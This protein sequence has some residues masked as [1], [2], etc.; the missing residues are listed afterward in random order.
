VHQIES[1]NPGFSFSRWTG[2]TP[3]E[4]ADLSQSAGKGQSHR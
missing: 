2:E 1:N 4:A 3:G